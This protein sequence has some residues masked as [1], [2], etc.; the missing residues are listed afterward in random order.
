MGRRR[1]L[2]GL[3]LLLLLSAGSGRAIDNGVGSVPIMGFDAWYAFSAFSSGPCGGTYHNK[4]GS[5]NYSRALT[6]TAE[7]MVSD[8]YRDAGKTMKF[9]LNMIFRYICSVSNFELSS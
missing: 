5:F 9:V 1:S 6:Q 7:V 3:L 8:G 4:N 2:L